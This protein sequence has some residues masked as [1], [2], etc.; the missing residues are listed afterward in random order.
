MNSTDYQK[1]LAAAEA[2]TETLLKQRADIDSRLARLKGTTE[3]LSRLL[4]I[5]KRPA[6]MRLVELMNQV[7]ADPGI[8][9][10][11]RQVLA[12]P[13]IPMSAAEIKFAL[14]SRG[15]DL[16]EY[17]NPGAVIHNTLTRLERQGEVMRLLSH[18]GQTMAY[19]LIA[20]RKV[21]HQ[22]VAEAE[23]VPNPHGKN[24]AEMLKET[25]EDKK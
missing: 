22:Q 21:L 18:S 25:Q 17:V 11:I 23:G 24:L 19:A 10:A 4:G 20:G 15:F 16:S 12:D 14:Q 7:P 3:A 2:E 5:D 13:G 6:A 1:A 8:T 9:N